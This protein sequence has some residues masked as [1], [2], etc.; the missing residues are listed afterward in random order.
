MD[1]PAERTN[2]G[3]A[4]PRPWREWAWLYLVNCAFTVVIELGYILGLSAG[5]HGAARLG[6]AMAVVSQAGVLNLIPALLTAWPMR[7]WP[8]RTSPRLFAGAMYALLQVSLLADIVIFRLFQRH[9]DSLVWNVLTT[10][11]AGDSVRVDTASVLIAA[12]VVLA[13]FGISM[14]LA[15]RVAP[16]LVVRRL[17]FG[18]VPLLVAALTERTTLATID[19][20]DNS[21]MQAVR[22]TLPLYQPLTI[23]G[24]ARKFGYKRPPGEVRV[25]PVSSGSLDLPRHPLGFGPDARTPNIIVIAVEGGRSDALDDKTMPNLSA[26]G[27]DSFRLMK[28][29]STGNETRFGIFGL[30]YGV[31][32]TYWNRVL[33]QSV[34]PPWL[35]LLASRGYEFQIMSCTDLNYPEFRQTA[36]AKLAGCITDHWNAPHVDRDRLMTDKF[37]GYLADRASR[38]NSSHPFF[39]FLFFDASHQ[40]YEHP[41]EDNVFESRLQSGEINY[42]KLAVSP[43]AAHA[44]KGSYLDSLHY[45][46]RQIGRI[47]KALQDTG[48]YQRTIIIVVGDHGEE[49]GELGHFGHVSSFNRFQTQTFGVLHLP[50][51]PPRAINHLTS[52]AAFVPSV[53][54][55]MGVTNA[56]ED[57]TTELPIQGTD[58]HQW[59]LISGWEN[60][61]LVK[62]D[63]IT[64]FKRSRTLYLDKDYQELPKG[65]PRRLSNGETLQAFKQMRAF[66]K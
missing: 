57:Y 23:K 45:I 14:A 47:V 19:L 10:K 59:T 63:S 64:V 41:L 33:A 30:L 51:E 62:E 48:E 2:A 53:L 17:R 24:L 39:G 7:R 36:F 38:T 3:A 11:G 54:T 58:V 31:P 42:A 4:N 34:S 52:H 65:D 22:D 35:D 25:L 66:L 6:F 9:F 1:N 61:A 21:T 16:R 32:A 44:L 12:T 49:F 46:D 60:S 40:P 55:W 29:F 37:L 27:R 50:G 13:V 5:L 8:R 15:L 26:L 56:L 18:L 28:H 43:A 20:W